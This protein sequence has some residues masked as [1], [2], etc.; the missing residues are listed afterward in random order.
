M[1]VEVV[2]DRQDRKAKASAPTLQSTQLGWGDPPEDL[3]SAIEAAR[4]VVRTRLPEQ[5]AAFD[6]A[7]LYTA[8]R[9]AG[10]AQGTSPQE[11]AVIDQV[12]AALDLT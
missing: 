1:N 4:E 7:L 8:V 5:A 11:H 2:M 3:T 10:A 6:A 12:R 9:T